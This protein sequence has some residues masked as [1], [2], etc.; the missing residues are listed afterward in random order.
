MVRLVTPQQLRDLAAWVEQYATGVDRIDEQTIAAILALYVGVDFYNPSEVAEAAQEAA[1]ASNAAALIVAGL[2]AQYIA[3]VS[4]LMSGED[5]PAP[6]VLLAPLRNG[7]DMRRVYQRPIKLFRRQVAKGVD[8]AEAF[9]QAMRLASVITQTNN[10]L[11]GRDALRQSMDALGDRI[12][13]T[14]YRRI[15][16]PELSRTGTCGLC[17]VAS[18]NVYSRRELMPLHGRCKCTV[19]PIVGARDGAGDPG[20]SLNNLSLGDFYALAGS[21]G[22]RDLKKV[23]VEVWEHGE[24]GPTL[25]YANQRHTSWEDL[26]IPKPGTASAA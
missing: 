5:L 6:A 12:G 2:A 15:V 8:P 24:Y 16:H 3:T 22:S 7:A 10:G 11:A 13:I 1:E 14:G 17:I 23:R 4:S 18:D 26:G 19:L 21:T 9:G 20:N 25:G